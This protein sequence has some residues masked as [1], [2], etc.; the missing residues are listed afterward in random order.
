MAQL[1]DIHIGS[2]IKQKL[3]ESSM[4]KQEFA[5]KIPCE[6]T[7][8]YDIFKRKSI[9]IELLIKISEILNFDFYSEIYLN[10]ETVNLTPKIVLHIDM[11][12][13][14]IEKSITWKDFYNFMKSIE[15]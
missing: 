11:S 2:I 1:K 14:I 5:D 8:V 15:N 4:T 13:Q 10:K 7:V 12:N 9:D 6:R 3:E